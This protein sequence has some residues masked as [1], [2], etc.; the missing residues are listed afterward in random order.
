M[1]KIRAA[2]IATAFFLSG[3]QALAAC[4][5]S[6]NAGNIT[7]NWDMTFALQSIN[8]TVTKSDNAA[9]DYWVGITKGGAATAANRR[10]VSG[11]RQLAYQLYKDNARTQILKD[12]S[13]APIT[14]NNEVLNTAFPVGTNITQT[15]Q[16]FLDIPSSSSL[17]PTIVKDG[18]YVDTYTLNVYEGSDPT[19]VGATP[20]TSASV[21]LTVNVPKMIRLSMVSSGGA[22]DDASL[23]RNVDMGTLITGTSATFDLRVRTNAGFEVTF[24]SAGNGKMRKTGVTTGPGVPYI[25]YANGTALDLSNS[26]TVPVT[27]LSGTGE[28][29]TNGLAYP[30]R[31]VI[32]N[33]TPAQFPG[34][35]KEDNI[36]VTATTTE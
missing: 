22:F 10:A 4:G 7:I 29:S 21:T 34:G 14:S 16:Y 1:R 5:L 9:C 30:I 25:L 19:L 32:D 2:L 27:G 36:L 33:Y 35:H 26:A 3:T 6:V 15:L 23:N 24:S 18:A 12:T 31:I 28:T 8:F 17:A 20:V 13:D 11:T